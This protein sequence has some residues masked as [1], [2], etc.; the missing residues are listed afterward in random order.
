[1]LRMKLEKLTKIAY[2]H[3]IISLISAYD[4]KVL[5]DKSDNDE[6]ILPK[7]GIFHTSQL[8]LRSKIGE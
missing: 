7:P 8:Q 6:L 5:T 2:E 4:N 1:M 3:Q